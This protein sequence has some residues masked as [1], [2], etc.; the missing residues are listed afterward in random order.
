[1]RSS[2]SSTPRARRAFWALLIVAALAMGILSS[3]LKRNPGPLT[4]LAVAVSGTVLLL[5]LTLACRIMIALDRAHRRA[6]G[7]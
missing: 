4:G 5:A 3:A 2:K 7:K 1:M 6:N